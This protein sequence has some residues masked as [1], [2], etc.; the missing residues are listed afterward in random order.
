MAGSARAPQRDRRRRGIWVV[1]ALAVGV[2]LSLVTPPFVMVLV[3][4]LSVILTRGDRPLAS[5]RRDR[6]MVMGIAA[7]GF[8][9]LVI[10]SLL[11]VSS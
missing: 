10:W 6:V 7:V 2:P 4:A 11:G 3:V 9:Y 1:G 8:A 5:R